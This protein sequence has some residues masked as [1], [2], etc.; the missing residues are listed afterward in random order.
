MFIAVYFYY[1][2]VNRQLPIIVLLYMI[3]LGYFRNIRTLTFERN[4]MS[5]LSQFISYLVFSP[6][7]TIINLLI[8]SILQIY[9]LLTVWKV[10]S[11][12][13]RENVEVGIEEGK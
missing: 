11:W 10:A 13:T 8:C 12:G 5:K 1:P 6:F 9:S 4:G 7:S 3:T 2:I